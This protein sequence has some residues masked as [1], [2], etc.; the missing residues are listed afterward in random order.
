MNIK[1][2]LA[3]LFDDISV[4]YKVATEI[5][6]TASDEMSEQEVLLKVKDKLSDKVYEKIK[7]AI[8]N[9]NIEKIISKLKKYSVFSITLFSEDYPEKLKN[10]AQPPL[11]LYCKGNKNLLNENSISIVGTRRPT[12]YGR[13]VTRRFASRL[14][15]AGLVTVSGLAF[16]LD[17]EVAMAT[18]SS[19]GKTIAVLG[20][21][22]DKIYPSQNTSLADKIVE[23]GGLLLSLYAP[24]KRPTKYSFVDRNRVISG[25]GLGTIIIEAGEG[26]GTLNTASHAI[27]QGKELFVIPANITSPASIGSNRLIEQFP[28]TFTIS[29][30]HVLEVLKVP[31]KKFFVKVAQKTDDGEDEKLILNLL[32]QQDLDF[33]TLKEKTHLDSKSLI[34][35]LTTMEI[36]ALIKKLPNNFYTLL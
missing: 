24:E 27:E 7:N 19:D 12:I 18:L 26:S 25:L 21:G 31:D 10:I 9:K 11:V 14:A 33:D 1:E 2:R 34:R 13:E 28:E 3:L 29:P 23:N 30:E 16:G 20:G 5:I 8:L 22:L 6:E 17:M 36:N 15:E 35:K 4:P 32:Y